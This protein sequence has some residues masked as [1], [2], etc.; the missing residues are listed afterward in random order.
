MARL[1]SAFESYMEPGVLGGGLDPLFELGL[2]HCAG[3]D[4]LI[5]LV[6]AHKWFSIAA[7]KGNAEARR[8]RQELADEMSKGELSKALRAAREWM[9][10]S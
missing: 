1:D 6:E 9:A 3:R 8:Y 2:K 4:C 5:D 7:L 10:R